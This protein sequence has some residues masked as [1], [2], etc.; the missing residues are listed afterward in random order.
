MVW[1]PSRRRI[2]AEQQTHNG[3]VNVNVGDVTIL[4]NVAV[5]V[6]ANVAA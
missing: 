2:P 3:L 5:G 4:E 1:L 6:A